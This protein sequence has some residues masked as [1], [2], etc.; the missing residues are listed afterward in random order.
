MAVDPCY[1]RP[2]VPAYPGP[3]T[4]WPTP[5]VARSSSPSAL[6]TPCRRR[7]APRTTSSTSC[8]RAMATATPGRSSSPVLQGPRRQ[9]R[10]HA[11][12][13]D[14]RP[15]RRKSTAAS[16]R[17]REIVLLA[18]GNALGLLFPVVNGVSA[19]NRREY[20]YL[21]AFSL[22]CLQ[23]DFEADKFPSFEAKR[24]KVLS[25]LG[26]DSWV[27]IRACNFGRTR[28]GMY[29][30]YAFFGGK[31]NVWCPI[32]YQ[33]F[34]TPPITDGNA[35][36]DPAGGPRA[37]RAPALPPQ[38]RPHARAQERLRH[39]DGRQGQVL[40]AVRDRPDADGTIRPPI[41]SPP[42]SRS[43]TN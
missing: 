27:T 19:T 16:P 21:T 38:G 41:R 13:A 10:P 23:K 29:S 36:R 17:I 28:E 24:T 7:L 37:P 1:R 18:H 33:F 6:S 2:A 8:P 39:R 31:A 40:H 22:A 5:T 43:S 12:G 34:G 25:K 20:K 9:E 11:R 30:V 15:G 4:P 32:Q 3:R 14:R 26:D 42:T 35:P